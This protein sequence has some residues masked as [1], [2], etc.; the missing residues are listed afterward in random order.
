[1]LRIPLESEGVLFIEYLRFCV[2]PTYVFFNWPNVYGTWL[3]TRSNR[4]II[5]Y[6]DGNGMA[7]F[8]VSLPLVEPKRISEQVMARI[9]IS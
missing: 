6:Q 3:V 5:R 8:A 7:A 9:A 1:M 2:Y 4:H